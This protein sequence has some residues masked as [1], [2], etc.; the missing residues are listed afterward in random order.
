MKVSELQSLNTG[1]TPTS[2]IAFTEAITFIAGTLTSSLRSMSIAINLA[3]APKVK[4]LT[5]FMCL[6]PKLSYYGASTS[7]PIGPEVR[8]GV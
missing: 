1:L 4:L 2:S 5:N 7:L 6:V 8:N 3:H